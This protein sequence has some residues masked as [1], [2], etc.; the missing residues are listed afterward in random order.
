MIPVVDDHS[1]LVEPTR[2]GFVTNYPPYRYW[3]TGFADTF[4]QEDPINIYVH[5]PYCIQRCAYCHYKTSTLKDNRKNEIDD[6]VDALCR[7]VEL[8]THKFHL[9]ERDTVSVYF[10]GGTPTL[11]SGRN[12]EKILECL[13]KN[14]KFRSPEITMEGEPVTLTKSKAAILR[15]LGVNRLSM[16]I[17]SFVDDVILRTGRH[18]T[19]RQAIKAIEIAKEIGCSIN[20]DLMSGLAGD[21]DESW[22]YTVD[23]AIDVDVDSLTVYKTEIYA[24]T[25]Y[26]AGIKNSILLVP[27]DDEEIR[28]AAYAM[29][30]I[31]SSGYNPSNFFTFVKDA[32]AAQRHTANRWRGQDMYG[33]GVSAFGSMGDYSIQNASDTNKYV[34]SLNSGNLP[35]ERGYR[36]N[37]RNLM[38]RHVVLGLKLIKLKRREFARKFGFDIAEL[39][40]NSLARLSNDGFVTVNDEEISL[41]KKGM[42]YGDFAGSTLASE[43]ESGAELRRSAEKS[44]VV[45]GDRYDS[46]R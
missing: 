44:A 2:K 35:I 4:S 22:A 10:G 9:D 29:E 23:R 12:L 39:C 13:D 38:A 31:L 43:I 18:D 33:F 16:G 25:A 6:Y 11:L 1:I 28:H 14:L 3:R 34:S 32:S 21:T 36:L 17:Q 7:E 42:L 30:R 40:G 27:S 15:S 19:E 20:I 41:T 5:T 37:H 26:Y 46:Y 45:V 8:A 24:N